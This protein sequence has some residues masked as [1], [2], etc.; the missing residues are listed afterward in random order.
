MNNEELKNR[1]LALVPESI[2]S[3]NKQF[4]TVTVPADKLHKLTVELRYSEDTAFDYLKNNN[5]VPWLELDAIR[6]EHMSGDCNHEGALL[7]LTGLALNLAAE[8]G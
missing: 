2:I 5:T 4:L 1:V 3:E 7:V 6:A 8:A